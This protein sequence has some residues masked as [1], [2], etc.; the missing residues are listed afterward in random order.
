M[1]KLGNKHIVVGTALNNIPSVNLLKRLG[2][3]QS[4][5]EQVSFYKDNNGKDIY[6]DGG[7]FF[8]LH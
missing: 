8:M 6:F 5:T 4:G 2:F 1:T 7:I 3:V